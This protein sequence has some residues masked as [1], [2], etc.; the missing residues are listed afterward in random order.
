NQATCLMWH[1]NAV[2][3]GFVR[4]LTGNVVWDNRKDCWTHNMRMRIGSKILLHEGVVPIR[5]KY[6]PGDIVLPTA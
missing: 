6:V 1:R 2:G 5:A 3:F 4:Q